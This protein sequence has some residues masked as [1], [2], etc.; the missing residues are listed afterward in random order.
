MYSVGQTQSNI[1]RINQNTDSVN[2]NNGKQNLGNGKISKDGFMQ[3]LLAQLKYQDPTNPVSDKEFVQ[4]QA[5]LTQ[6]E[7]LDELSATLKESTYLSQAAGLTGKFVTV[8]GSDGNEATGR[9]NQVELG[10]DSIGVNVN[11]KSY[12][13]SQI[14]MIYETQPTT[15]PTP[16]TP[17]SPT[18][19]PRI[20][21][22]PT[23]TTEPAK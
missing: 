23:T 19:V 12:L 11:G 15:T 14:K 21:T 18:P 8:K 2:F 10:K 22:S 16:S 7:K 9:V 4:Q 1:D 3:L 6:I 5:V 20:I 13:A 17:V